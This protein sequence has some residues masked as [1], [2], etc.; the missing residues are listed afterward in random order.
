M[1]KG[2]G[3]YCA[4]PTVE[5]IREP[6]NASLAHANRRIQYCPRFNWCCVLFLPAAVSLFFSKAFLNLEALFLL[7][8][9]L[10]YSLSMLSPLL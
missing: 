10:Y 2:D 3:D 9:L 5:C 4:G 1:S 6:I 8:N 7:Q